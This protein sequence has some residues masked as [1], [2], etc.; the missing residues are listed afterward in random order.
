MTV[1]NI[2][3]ENKRRWTALNKFG[4]YH[5]GLCQAIGT[6]LTGVGKSHAQLFTASQ[7][8][9]EAGQVMWRRNNQ[10]IPNAGQHKGSE[11]IIDHRL[12]VNWQ[13]LFRSRHRHRVQAS[14]AS[15]R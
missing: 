15:S 1:E 3:A 7:Q 11:R 6:S 12:V 9:L 14:T 10:D 8:G 13:K 4:S 5:E 2:V